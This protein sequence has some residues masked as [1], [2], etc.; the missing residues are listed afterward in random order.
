LIYPEKTAV[1][2]DG[3]IAIYHFITLEKNVLTIL[4]IKKLITMRLMQVFYYGKRKYIEM[5]NSPKSIEGNTNG[6]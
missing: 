5:I 3:T 2:W 6:C 4:M 1:A